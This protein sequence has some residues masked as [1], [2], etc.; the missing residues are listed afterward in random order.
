MTQFTHPVSLRPEDF[1]DPIETGKA[2]NE[3][4]Q[5]PAKGT[6]WGDF[7]FLLWNELANEHPEANVFGYFGRRSIINEYFGSPVA[8]KPGLGFQML[9]QNEAEFQRKFFDIPI[10]AVYETAGTDASI[11]KVL[12]VYENLLYKKRVENAYEQTGGGFG[13]AA[14]QLTGG[15]YAGVTSPTSLALGIPVSR[16]VGGLSL[17]KNLRL[18]AASSPVVKTVFSAAGAT[19]IDGAFQGLAG[20]ILQESVIAATQTDP[21]RDPITNV[22]NATVF[23][24]ALG[25]VTGG[26]GAA[27]LLAAGR[28]LQKTMGAQTAKALSDAPPI[29]K[30]TTAHAV[31][32][33][34]DV[35]SQVEIDALSRQLESAK[36]LVQAETELD[37]LL[38]GR[39]Q[40]PEVAARL[41][42]A[43]R[44][45]DVLLS[46][47]P[48]TPDS[49]KAI[50]EANFALDKMTFGEEITPQEGIRLRRIQE[51]VAR[52]ASILKEQEAVSKENLRK[53]EE[54]LDRALAGDNPDP[55]AAA[56]IAE[57]NRKLDEMAAEDTRLLQSTERAQAKLDRALDEVLG[58][59]S[60][61]RPFQD[62]QEAATASPVIQAVADEADAAASLEA[63]ASVVLAA[64]EATKDTFSLFKDRVREKT[65]GLKAGPETVQASLEEVAKR[66]G[67]AATSLSSVADSWDF[68]R[69]YFTRAGL[70]P[71]ELSEALSGFSGKAEGTLTD[72]ETVEVFRLLLTVGGKDFAQTFIRQFGS[73]VE[74]TGVE[75][76][77]A[78]SV[79]AQRLLA[80]QDIGFF[81]GISDEMDTV[82]EAL[83]DGYVPQTTP[84]IV[85]NI[86]SAASKRRGV[87]F[88]RNPAFDIEAEIKNAKQ[89]PVP[90]TY[91]PVTDSQ[92]NGVVTPEDLT[93][94]EVVSSEATPEI[95]EEYGKLWLDYLALQ[96]RK[97]TKRKDFKPAVEARKLLSRI[98]ELRGKYNLSEADI[99]A[100]LTS[101]AANRGATLVDHPELQA[102]LFPNTGRHTPLEW[103][104]RLSMGDQTAW[105]DAYDNGLFSQTEQS[106][107]EQMNESPQVKEW[108]GKWFTAMDPDVR[109][110][111]SVGIQVHRAGGD[112]GQAVARI[113]PDSLEAARVSR[114]INNLSQAL[115]RRL[116]LGQSGNRIL[117]GKD[118]DATALIHEVV[119]ALVGTTMTKRD[120]ANMVRMFE[121]SHSL[122]DPV[123]LRSVL[124][125]DGPKSK[126]PRWNELTQA[127]KRVAL[128]AES[129]KAKGWL[130]GPE[131]HLSSWS[132]E[133]ITEFAE[134]H[135]VELFM[136]K[137]ALKE[138]WNESRS[139]WSKIR[140]WFRWIAFSDP[141][142]AFRSLSSRFE[143]AM[144]RGNKRT[145]LA[146]REVLATRYGRG[147]FVAGYNRLT[148]AIATAEAT[149]A[150]DASL[151]SRTRLGR[152]VEDTKARF[153]VI[154][155]MFE[156][157]GVPFTPEA[158]QK[159]SVQDLTRL[160]VDNLEEA[161]S[162]FPSLTEIR[163]LAQLGLIDKYH[164]SL[165]ALY[166]PGDNPDWAYAGNKKTLDQTFE[167]LSSGADEKAPRGFNARDLNPI[168][169]FARVSK[170]LGGT[171]FIP[172]IQLFDSPISLRTHNLARALFSDIGLTNMDVRPGTVRNAESRMEL[173]QITAN[174]VRE[175]IAR[176]FWLEQ[177][178]QGKAPTLM[179]SLG[180][181]A[182]QRTQIAE[183][184]VDYLDFATKVV[185]GLRDSN[186]ISGKDVS[187][188]V[189]EAFKVT[190]KWFDDLIPDLKEA[191]VIDDVALQAF[192]NEK[193]GYTDYF[194][195]N[196][197]VDRIVANKETFIKLAMKD[198]AAGRAANDLKPLPDAAL[199][200][201]AEAFWDTQVR[202]K[203]VDFDHTGKAGRHEDTAGSVIDSR[204]VKLH[205]P[206]A[207]A[208]EGF[209]IEDLDKTLNNYTAKWASRAYATRAVMDSMGLPEAEFIQNLS[210]GQIVYPTREAFHS[211]RKKVAKAEAKMEAS[212]ANYKTIKEAAKKKQ[213]A[214]ESLTALEEL[215]L[216]ENQT[217]WVAKSLTPEEKIY[218]EG[219][220]RQGLKPYLKQP[221]DIFDVILEDLKR[222]YNETFK[223]AGA[224]GSAIK[225]QRVRKENSRNLETFHLAIDRLLGTSEPVASAT[226]LALADTSKNIATGGLL[227]KLIFMQMHDNANLV[228][229]DLHPGGEAEVRSRTLQLAKVALSMPKEAAARLAKIMESRSN[230]AFRGD[231][232]NLSERT[233]GI[234]EEVTD[235][236]N[237]SRNPFVRGAKKALV[238]ANKVSRTLTDTAFNLSGA[239]GFDRGSRVVQAGYTHSVIAETL[240]RYLKV[241]DLIDSGKNPTLDDL[242]RLGFPKSNK[243]YALNRAGFN[244]ENATLL[245]EYHVESDTKGLSYIDTPR[246]M[247][248]AE[249]ALRA[250]DEARA[251]LL[252]NTA[253]DF[254][255]MMIERVNA[256]MGV[257]GSSTK[258]TFIETKEIGPFFDVFV[259]WVS[260]TLQ[261]II[262]HLP[263]HPLGDQLQWM[264]STWIW[265]IATT[266]LAAAATGSLADQMRD[267]EKPG[268]YR[269]YMTSMALRTHL[270]GSYMGNLFQG[271]LYRGEPSMTPP[272]LGYVP[273]F[274]NRAST[275]VKDMWAIAHGDPTTKWSDPETQKQFFRL[276]QM[277]PVVNLWYL[278]GAARYISQQ[279]IQ[280]TQPVGSNE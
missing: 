217:E 50:K 190:R 35:L 103:E 193:T 249:T 181:K 166:N 241:L 216:K 111:F 122:G 207:F 116:E 242:R 266:T 270:A 36:R 276:T 32:A 37:N 164:D 158:I 53:G 33:A 115:D 22:S 72:D 155:E 176:E 126:A 71:A 206:T 172:A 201:Q 88:V 101:M 65:E 251:S 252:R 39:P 280:E 254:E 246:M 54:A 219:P 95:R 20:G 24:A 226:T 14:A 147:Y 25:G 135:F 67:V 236:A 144:F 185:N 171:Q 130:N 168:N 179:E 234:L 83:P 277:I 160:S 119:H 159:A 210:A 58:N 21:D 91:K 41:E 26:A 34:S 143:A 235:E 200:E 258:P 113:I 19:T 89:N 44:D 68:T 13:S 222:E 108:M 117:L 146:L 203:T 61:L 51:K 121:E 3:L 265:G 55:E 136:Q 225:A 261:N 133:A 195:Q 100:Q 104:R 208:N 45:L 262:R 16:A 257:A 2:G 49:A 46:G 177:K 40:N 128:Y 125:F 79:P 227:P 260:S 42:K 102:A 161:V 163:T 6:S 110:A 228:M 268:G 259:S 11:A 8:D 237:A 220:L 271:L 250:G 90:E 81:R 76:R 140:D 43:E 150:S 38:A 187:P 48:F 174:E 170:H 274:W 255:A 107:M 162:A 165:S 149:G 188:H 82:L 263:Q 173:R 69:E 17:I 12:E 134:E 99:P 245:L 127:Q 84:F 66:K 230:T 141:I 18:A 269:R 191:G 153:P 211:I 114:H 256:T 178:R 64:D 7:S 167:A 62:Q 239:K 86:H 120:L 118:A 180:S 124:D 202:K 175:V 152:F 63:P 98:E 80:K 267:M 253:Q 278:N 142:A 154:A 75:G 231:P 74:G 189:L 145:P 28:G 92:S 224:S 229:T 221:F 73:T 223:A 247:L 9:R 194:P 148:E 196:W 47:K 106:V 70:N 218:F 96:E 205:D 10:Q 183:N 279:A 109:D 105:K 52:T 182:T 112:I 94:T 215:S 184:H 244:R 5:P 212:K 213:K 151:A 56:R 137:T 214:G 85:E 192:F 23:G 199:R 97:Y 186:T 209:F 264:A 78:K 197:D 15:L 57:A 243:F 123:A 240:T 169:L 30:D 156:D 27:L 139:I 87:R 93:P 198:F 157:S 233:R 232:A 129:V 272:T 248:D 138:I 275:V 204:Q 31:E 238:K 132:P 59:D 273:Q 4:L 1:R 29:P 77:M 60:Y 131:E